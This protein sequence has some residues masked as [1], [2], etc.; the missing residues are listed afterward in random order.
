[1]TTTVPSFIDSNLPCNINDELPTISNYKSLV[2]VWPTTRIAKIA[3][4]QKKA[5]KK[6]STSVPTHIQ[7]EADALKALYHHHKEML[8]LMGNVSLF[9]LD[10]AIGDLG[11]SCGVGAESYCLFMSYSK[12]VEKE[13][14]PQATEGVSLAKRNRLI[15]NKW[16]SLY[17]ME[18]LFFQPFIFYIL[19]GLCSPKKY[20]PLNLTPKE[21]NKL[22]TLYDETVSNAKV[23]K[24]YASVLNGNL[25]G[26]LLADHNQLSRKCVE[27]FHSEIQ[28]KSTCMVFSYHF[29]AAGT[30][31][32][33]SEG[34][35]CDEWCLEFTLHEDMSEYAC[36]K[37]NF[38][39]IFATQTQGALVE[40]TVAAAIG[41]K[42]KSHG[43][44]P[45]QP[46][47]IVKAKLS[48]GLCAQLG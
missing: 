16:S 40:D 27:T 9:T 17:D 33:T 38:P 31:P 11:S 15:G 48:A 7:K 24:V 32:P 21:R 5:G 1:L 20:K 26:Q 14:M 28:S 46:A 43:A 34:K 36:T 29:L 30:H 18:Q 12:F 10:K 44:K 39:V 25:Q 13:Y 23:A 22:Q 3:E 41:S 35:G 8:A 6:L 42:S 45:K 37:C 19:S 2:N 4:E 47:D